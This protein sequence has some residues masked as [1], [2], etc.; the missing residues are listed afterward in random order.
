MKVRGGCLC[1]RHTKELIDV[2]T[3]V[4]EDWYFAQ[5]LGEEGLGVFEGTEWW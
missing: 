1:K 4:V 3:V 5:M 2:A